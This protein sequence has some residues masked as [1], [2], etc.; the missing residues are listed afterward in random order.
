[1]PR[2]NGIREI[3]TLQQCENEAEYE[4]EGLVVRFGTPL[5]SYLC[6]Q[7]KAAWEQLHPDWHN[8]SMMKYNRFKVKF[9]PISDS[10]MEHG[11]SEIS[12][13]DKITPKFYGIKEWE[14]KRKKVEMEWEE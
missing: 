9:T 13:I 12:N 8:R 11:A 5:K 2:C 10:E 4:V 14:E 1:M 6:G 7:C 3:G